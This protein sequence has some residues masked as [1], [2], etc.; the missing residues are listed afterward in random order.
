MQHHCNAQCSYSPST[1]RPSHLITSHHTHPSLTP[2]PPPCPLSP[3]S[4]TI[5][6]SFPQ[7]KTSYLDLI[8]DPTAG[9]PEDKLRLFAIYY[10]LAQDMLDVSVCVCVVCVRVC[11]VC[12]WCVYVFMCLVFVCGCFVCGCV[13][14]CG[15]WMY[16]HVLRSGRKGR[17]EGEL[18]KYYCSVFSAE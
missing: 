9:T 14:L 8:K 2:H 17:R 16:M 11:G 6:P 13:C 12:V 1:T 4:P 15:V 5:S 10:I 18:V 3:P 7:D